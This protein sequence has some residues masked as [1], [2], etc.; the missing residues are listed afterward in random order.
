MCLDTI[1]ISMLDATRMRLPFTSACLSLWLVVCAV[2]G[3]RHEADVRHVIDGAG[4]SVHAAMLVGEHTSKQSDVHG[5]QGAVETD[6][7]L[8]LAAHHQAR[9]SAL[10][11]VRI[12]RIE[13][14]AT[15]AIA[16]MV[17]TSV[18]AIVYRFAPKTSPPLHA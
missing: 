4:N 10:A 11:P 13:R 17:A 14:A 15:L 12:V 1:Y 5:A 18:A 9:V 7:C 8:V 3:A 6:A 16:R 2:F